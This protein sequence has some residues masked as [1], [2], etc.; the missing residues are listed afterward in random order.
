MSGDTFPTGKPGTGPVS[1]DGLM[2]PAGQPLRPATSGT[3]ACQ[4]H[5]CAPPAG[6]DSDAPC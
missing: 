6:P 1:L 2:A 4:A 5:G 3:D